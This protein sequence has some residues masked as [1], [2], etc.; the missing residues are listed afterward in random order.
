MHRVAPGS[1]RGY[2]THKSAELTAFRSYQRTH[3]QAVTTLD[4]ASSAGVASQHNI[5]SSLSNQVCVSN[6]GGAVTRSALTDTTGRSPNIKVNNDNGGAEFVDGEAT[7]PFSSPPAYDEIC[8][9]TRYPS[10]P[11]PVSANSLPPS[12]PNILPPVYSPPKQRKK[13]RVKYVYDEQLL[14]QD[15]SRRAAEQH[16]KEQQGMRL[17]AIIPSF[18]INDLLPSGRSVREGVGGVY[19]GDTEKRRRRRRRVCARPGDGQQVLGQQACNMYTE[20][21]MDS[22]TT[23][24]SAH[25]VHGATC[26]RSDRFDRSRAG[27]D[28]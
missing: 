15:A 23:G 25:T 22:D 14:I 27:V 12:Y 21:R 26:D 24:L 8:D 4:S 16:A 3:D 28:V 20:C 1:R 7:H 6:P 2:R 10:D 11:S 17:F 19:R 18:N 5:I 13:A 9:P